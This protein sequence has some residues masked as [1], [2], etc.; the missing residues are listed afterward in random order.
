MKLLEVV[1]PPSI[2]H[3]CYTGKTFWEENFT[4][5]ENLF[6]AVNMKNCGRRNIRKHKDINFSDKYVIVD[7]SS[8]FDSLEKMKITSLESKVKLER[9]GKGLITSLGFKAKVRP[10]KYKK[11]RYAIENVS[12]KDLYKIIKE[13]EK[14]DKLPYEK[15]RPK[16]E[17]TDSYFHLARQLTKCMMRS[18]DLNW[19]NHGGYTKTTDQY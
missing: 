5:Q 7:I 16:H 3:G 1:I 12:K 17:P 9:S 2:Y 8:K 10:Y 19:H 6:L 15:K 18:D 4:G 14:I 11:S 13:F